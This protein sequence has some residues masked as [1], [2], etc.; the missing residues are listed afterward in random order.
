MA[1]MASVGQ[2]ITDAI[3]KQDLGTR[4]DDV[5]AE[6]WRKGITLEEL[7]RHVE[8]RYI[9][10]VL[11]YHKGNQCHAAAA[12]GM[13]RN[14]LHRYLVELEIDPRSGRKPMRTYSPPVQKVG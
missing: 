10:R 5:I 1:Q 3:K 2:I 6:A 8:A 11:E 7:R 9:A 12:L 13:H 14:T 4:T